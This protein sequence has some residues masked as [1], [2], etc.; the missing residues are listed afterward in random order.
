[1]IKLL[2][3]EDDVNL[4]YILKSSL[5]EIIGNY[6]VKTAENGQE[7]LALWE[8]FQPDI[9]VSDIEMPVLNGVEM[10]K[11][12]RWKDT[13]IPII[14]ATNKTTTKDVMV[15][16]EAGVDNYVKK[17]FLPEEL[18]AHIQ[19][20]IRLKSNVCLSSKKQAHPIGKY[21]FDP[22]RQLLI[23]NSVEHT[24]SPRESAILEVLF[25]HKQEIVKRDEIL[26]R[27]WGSNNFYSSRSLDVFITKMRKYL[28]KDPSVT[29]K[30]LKGV[31]LIL[32]FE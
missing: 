12:I 29:I 3:I 31:G 10:V 1:M 6:E 19:A 5:E 7:G 20:L 8:T 27:F 13:N 25:E 18:D 24:L 9:I 32:N 26:T 28:S 22:K 11:Q 14:F 16:Y 23:Y 21:L 2:L 30:N 4:G 15:G 17:P